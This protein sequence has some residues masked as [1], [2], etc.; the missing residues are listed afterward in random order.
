MHEC[1]VTYYI[2]HTLAGNCKASNDVDVS[3][4]DL[5]YELPVLHE[6]LHARSLAA[7]VADDVLSR[8]PDDGNL[9]R[10]PQLAF[11]ATYGK[12][13]T[14]DVRIFKTTSATNSAFDS[15]FNTKYHVL[16][17][18][19]EPGVPNWYL[20]SPFF[21]NTWMRWLF[22]SATTMSSSTPRQKPCGELNWPLAGPSC[23]NLHLKQMNQETGMSLKQKLLLLV[24]TLMPE[25]QFNALQLQIINKEKQKQMH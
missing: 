22:V 4:G 15:I 1:S 13:V 8:R 5:L 10:I 19:F 20:N 17:R 25:P 7:A 23:P 2:L 11:L 3:D 6:Q 24:E 14:D 16:L 12:R 21:S 18:P 9:A